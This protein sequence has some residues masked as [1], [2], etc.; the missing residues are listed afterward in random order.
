MYLKS[1]LRG[2]FETRSKNYFCFVS[3]EPKLFSRARTWPFTNPGALE[4]CL[5]RAA[6]FIH[7]KASQKGLRGNFL[8]IGSFGLNSKNIHLNDLRLIK[9]F[10]GKLFKL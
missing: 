3:F 9:V 8:D 5:F 7:R 10:T 4:I 6:F 1:Y 2:L